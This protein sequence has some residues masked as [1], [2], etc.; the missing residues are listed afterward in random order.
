MPL[1]ILIHRKGETHGPYDREAV[2]GFIQEK[3]ASLR[4]WAS[5]EDSEERVRLEYLLRDEETLPEDNPE[6]AETVAKIKDLVEKDRVEHAVDL[7][8]GLND[9]KLFEA[10]LGECHV[11]EE[12]EPY[13][14]FPP[15]GNAR[16]ILELVANCPPEAD[17]HPYL[18]LENL[19]VL[20]GR[21]KDLTDLSPVA[22]LT[23]LD[24]LALWDN[25]VTDLSP[26]AQLPKLR[27]LDF[28]R[29][30]VRDLSPLAK[31]GGS[32]V[33]LYAR[34][35]RI[36]DLSPL[37]SLKKLK[38]L[39]LGGNQISDLAP[40]ADLPKLTWLKLEGNQ[41]TDLSPLVKLS[42]LTRLNIEQNPINDM[43]KAI[44]ENALPNCE[45]KVSPY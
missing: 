7:V 16:F 1:K 34:F 42:K 27:R 38:W 24:T 21:C 44:L 4:D 22:R 13:L 20:D 39:W 40:L 3:R 23:S 29:N 14:W 5:F 2:E 19:N 9:P 36:S 45:I 10:L 18:R 32:L 26:L 15:N 41:I 11:D 6:L 30:Q 37:A 33:E 8:C 25:K 17:I 35:N 28:G 12:R 31:L 43:Q